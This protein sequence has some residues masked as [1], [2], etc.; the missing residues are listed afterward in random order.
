MDL[1]V[2]PGGDDTWSGRRPDPGP[3]G[4]GPFRTPARALSELARVR[5]LQPGEPV[6]VW[7]RGGT[8]CLETPLV[9]TPDHG[10]AAGGPRVTLAAYGAERPVL[11]AGRRVDGWRPDSLRGRP[12]WVADLPEVR[13]GRWVFHQL[14]VDGGRRLRPRLPDPRAPLGTRLYRIAALPDVTADT[15]W[16][17]GQERVVFAPGDVAA[18]WRNLEDVEVVALH[19]WVESRLPVA[20]VDPERRLVTFRRR[21][22]FRLTD[23]FRAQ[24][25]RY[26]VD[27]V[28][29]ALGEPGQWYLDRPSGTLWYLP[30]PGEVPDKTEVYAPVGPQ[31]VRLEGTPDRPLENVELRGLTFAHTEWRLPPD[32]PAGAPQAAVHVPGAVY[33]GHARGCTL[34]RCRVQQVGTYAVEVGPGCSGTEILECVF[35]DLG[36]GGVKVA[37]G[38]T[39]TTIARC[40]I[41]PGGLHYHSAVGV[42]ILDSPDNRVVDNHIHHFC[43]TGV[44]LGWVWGYGPSQARNNVVERNHIHDIG[45]G[46]LND[47]GGIYTL[48]VQP[49]TVLRRNRIHDVRSDGY[50]GWGIYLDEGSTDILV[51]ENLVWR[52]KTGG[53]HQHYGRDNLI[54]NNIFAYAAEGQIQRTRLEEHRSFRFERNIVYIDH[55]PV[56]HGNWQRPGAD[57]DYNLYWHAA[58]G[59]LDF[60]G[61][62]SFAD[63]QALGADTHSLVADPRFG[64]PALGDF[65]L[66]PDSPA[67]RLGFV[68][69]PAGPAEPSG[70]GRP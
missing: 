38:S 17:Q 32:G 70:D 25:A 45:Q 61:G 14:F 19:F 43:Y 2:S 60:G 15:P 69:F 10:G 49:G 27:N 5:R 1:F 39:R 37:S 23:D 65:T 56:L 16:N 57:F 42:L 34:R 55:G 35:A 20:A 22:V 9:L 11:S 53:L 47:L 58:G 31:V 48:G 64:D 40:E 54:R 21:S 4:H 24:G 46:V 67:H 30:L 12:A 51:E 26:Y 18:S 29:E 33:L 63:W 68:P 36:A 62:R 59:P 3:G 44:S 7:L 8:Y 28:F 52:T 41:G 6:T 66:P 50:G 13:A